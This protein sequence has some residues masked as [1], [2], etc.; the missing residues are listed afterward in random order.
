MKKLLILTSFMS[1]ILAGYN[2]NAFASSANAAMSCPA[3]APQFTTEIGLAAIKQWGKNAYKHSP[4][5]PKGYS[6]ANVAA[7]YFTLS[8]YAP[9]AVLLPTVS[10][11]S[12]VGTQGIYDYFINFLQENPVMSKVPMTGGTTLAGCGEGVISGYYNFVLQ[13]AGETPKHVHARY[14][15]QF[16]YSAKPREVSLKLIGNSDGENVIKYTQPV[17]WY[18]KLQNSAVL[19]VEHEEFSSK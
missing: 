8:S 12:R 18:I 11:V 16:E 2:T 5:G 13:K 10:Q 6:S 7:A 3:D 4:K 17:G 14:T 1:F 15:M 9:D 19:P